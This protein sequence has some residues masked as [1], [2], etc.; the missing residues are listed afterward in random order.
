MRLLLRELAQ[1][2][3]LLLESELVDGGEAGTL[4]LELKSVLLLLEANNLVKGLGVNVLLAAN[5]VINPLADS[6]LLG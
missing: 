6:L 1:L 5:G 4:L 2:L 3:L